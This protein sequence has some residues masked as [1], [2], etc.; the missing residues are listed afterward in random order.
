MM[1]FDKYVPFNQRPNLC[2]LRANIFSGSL[3]LLPRCPFL[4]PAWHLLP[5]GLSFLHGR[6]QV[7]NMGQQ[8]TSTQ[9]IVVLPKLVSHASS[10]DL[11]NPKILMQ[12]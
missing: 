9:I 11:T 6:L 1:H 2:C 3:D 12:A 10:I 4:G 7:H 5:L 8:A